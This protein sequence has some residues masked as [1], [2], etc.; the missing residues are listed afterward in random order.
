MNIRSDQKE[1]PPASIQ[2]TRAEIK[3]RMMKNRRTEHKDQEVDTNHFHRTIIKSKFDL[4]ARIEEDPDPLI[5]RTR[6][7]LAAA[8]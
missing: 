5:L 1:D 2:G 3:M 6:C 8:R 4:P 7:V